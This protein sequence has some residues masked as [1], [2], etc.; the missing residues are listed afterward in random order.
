M[1]AAFLGG[2]G[3]GTDEGAV[4]LREQGVGSFEE[5]RVVTPSGNTKNTREL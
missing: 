1:R 4:E 3:G 5:S 2:G